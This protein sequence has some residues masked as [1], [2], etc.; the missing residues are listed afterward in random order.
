MKL[1]VAAAVIALAFTT[2]FT[3]SK[4]TPAEA[5][6]T[7]ETTVAPVDPAAPAA[8]GTTTETTV[9]PATN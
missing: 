4:N 6:A 3:C 8:E 2:G 1:I 7:T 9:A 5:P